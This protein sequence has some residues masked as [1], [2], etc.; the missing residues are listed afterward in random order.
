[1]SAIQLNTENRFF[2]YPHL[3]EALLLD[4][5]FV[6]LMILAENGHK[7]KRLRARQPLQVIRETSRE[8]NKQVCL[9][10]FL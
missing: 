8:E 4:V 2:H 5:C 6:D 7:P 1:M 3:A 10:R 9:R